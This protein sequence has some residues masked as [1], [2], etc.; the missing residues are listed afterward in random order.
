MN[1]FATKKLSP[2]SWGDIVA[3]DAA[4][5]PFARNAQKPQCNYMVVDAATGEVFEN[6]LTEDEAHEAYH[7]WA[8]GPAHRAQN[9][10]VQ[11][12]RS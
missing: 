7:V 12:V 5:P 3:V 6:A 11:E 9:L 8:D 2:Y 4:F 10:V 1:Y